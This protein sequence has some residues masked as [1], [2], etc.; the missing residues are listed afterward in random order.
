MPDDGLEF[1]KNEAMRLKRQ[2]Y[3]VAADNE[4]LWS[5]AVLAVQDYH[6]LQEA[7]A[8]AKAEGKRVFPCPCPI[9]KAVEAI[10]ADLRE[11]LK[12]DRARLEATGE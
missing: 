9:C 4:A 12:A 10:P 2:L 6:W 11:R 7:V 8:E 5:L 1:W 3:G